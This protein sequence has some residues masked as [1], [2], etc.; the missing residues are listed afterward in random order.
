V[1]YG[2]RRMR[3]DAEDKARN[4]ELGSININFLSC[5]WRLW[6]W[7]SFGSWTNLAKATTIMLATMSKLVHCRLVEVWTDSAD[8]AQ[9]IQVPARS[10]LP[11][12][13]TL[14]YKLY[15][16]PNATQ[17]IYATLTAQSC[18]DL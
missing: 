10:S 5:P 13:V 14:G 2:V 18:K 1:V 17:R 12:V 8:T 6:V 3:Y 9:V 16:E 11:A 4:K 15:Q 7:A